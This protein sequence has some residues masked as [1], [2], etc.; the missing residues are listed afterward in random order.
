MPVNI[1]AL[2]SA[3]GALIALQWPSD[4]TNP[5]FAGLRVSYWL[6]II[7]VVVG[8]VPFVWWLRRR[9]TAGDPVDP[10]ALADEMEART[11]S[12]P[13]SSL[14][15]SPRW[16]RRERAEHCEWAWP[17]GAAPTRN[18]HGCRSRCVDVRSR[19]PIGL[20]LLTSTQRGLHEIDAL[21]RDGQW[22]VLTPRHRE[23]FEPLRTRSGVTLICSDSTTWKSDPSSTIAVGSAIHGRETVMVSPRDEMR[24]SGGR[25]IRAAP[26][27][28]MWRQ[29][30]ERA[31]TAGSRSG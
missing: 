23:I 10:E 11:D 14:R 13:L 28:R 24:R 3:A 7:P 19:V 2:I 20:R 21:G 4:L 16:N 17:S 18:Q 8:L 12:A 1:V 31:W 22:R 5:V 27:A 25:P 9:R 29:P 26:G 30:H 15:R 6:F